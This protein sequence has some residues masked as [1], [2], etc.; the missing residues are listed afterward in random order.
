EGASRAE[1][2]FIPPPYSGRTGSATLVAARPRCAS[3]VKP[4]FKD[5]KALPLFSQALEKITEWQ[6]YVSAES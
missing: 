1:V 5:W 4:F 3:A 2:V 6:N